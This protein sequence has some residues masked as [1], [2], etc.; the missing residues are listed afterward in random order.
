M[1]DTNELRKMCDTIRV[2]ALRMT[3][4]AASG[5]PSSCFSCVEIIGVV[6]LDIM[7]IDPDDPTKFDRDRFVLSKGHA[8]PAYYSALSLKGFIPREEL[9][10]LRAIGSR[11]QGHPDMNKTPGVDFSTG[12]LGMGLSVANGM[13]LACRLN[14]ASS[15]IYV[16]LGDGELQEGQIWEAAMTAGHHKLSNVIAIVDRNKLQCDGLTEDIKSI[17]PLDAKFKAF[18]WRVF[19]VDGHD[20]GAL[21]KVIRDAQTPYDGPTVIIADTLK[22]KGVSCMEDQLNWHGKPLKGEAFEEALKECEQV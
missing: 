1:I 22:G 7:N 11:L 17:E 3:T 13:A 8:A 16:L 18:G 19:F 10:S 20:V 4:D 12:S 21:Q 5:H 6:I 14:K 9:Y 15:R 2:D